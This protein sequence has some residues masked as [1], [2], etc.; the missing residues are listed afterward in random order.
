MAS[1]LACWPVLGGASVPRLVSVRERELRREGGRS[2][3][4]YVK[5]VSVIHPQGASRIL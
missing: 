2:L 3:L 4:A 5:E 1:K